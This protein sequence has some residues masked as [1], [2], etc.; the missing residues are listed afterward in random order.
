[1]MRSPGNLFFV[2]WKSEIVN[3]Y[4]FR[5]MLLM[6]SI[7]SIEREIDMRDGSQWLIDDERSNP[8]S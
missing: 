6:L 4:I 2:Q 3:H 7:K 8:A 5:Q 1:M